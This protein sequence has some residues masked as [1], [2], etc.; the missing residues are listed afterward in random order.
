MGLSGSMLG[1]KR[2]WHFGV[3]TTPVWHQ[4]AL[5]SL[6]SCFLCS[7]SPLDICEEKESQLRPACR[8]GSSGPEDPGI[9]V[10]RGHQGL[11]NLRLCHEP[12]QCL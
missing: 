11:Q 9:C 7:L 10:V 12:L 3:C 2:C 6:H 5:G 1:G 8:Q 4:L